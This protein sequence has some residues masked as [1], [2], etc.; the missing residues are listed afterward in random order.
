LTSCHTASKPARRCASAFVAASSIASSFALHF[1]AA[2]N[3][4][5]LAL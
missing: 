5:F 1:V 3:D 2:T 4:Q